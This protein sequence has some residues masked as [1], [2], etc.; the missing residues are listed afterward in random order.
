MRSDQAIKDG[1][2]NSPRG[3][4]IGG[5]PKGSKNG[6]TMDFDKVDGTGI[7]S[8]DIA[9][10]N[11]ASVSMQAI[12][13]GD[14]ADPAANGVRGKYS[15]AQLQASKAG[16]A[17]THLA[18]VDPTKKEQY[19]SDADFEKYMKSPRSEFNAMKLWKQQQIKKAAGLY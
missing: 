15:L 18:D 4:G 14:F 11:A 2:P 3:N 17:D 13:S 9:D 16:N 1:G 5:T 12:L 6:M 8:K 10:K 19:L 7:S